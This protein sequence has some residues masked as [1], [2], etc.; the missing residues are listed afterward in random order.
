MTD[1][2]E[3]AR[4]IA[5]SLL[6]KL[7]TECGHECVDHCFECGVKEIAAAL[8]EYGAT[9]YQRGKD[10]LTMAVEAMRVK[11]EAE[12][13]ARGQKETTEAYEKQIKE[14]LEVEYRRG[15]DKAIHEMMEHRCES[16]DDVIEVLA[17]IMEKLQRGQENKK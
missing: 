4:G 10:M 15:V 1:P 17:D 13:H 2:Q 12:G 11:A 3:I 7:D 16:G 9:E 8:V 6:R 14:W 5:E